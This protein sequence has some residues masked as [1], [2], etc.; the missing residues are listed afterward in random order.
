M[1]I[2]TIRGWASRLRDQ[3]HANRRT[4][5]QSL[6]AGSATRRLSSFAAMGHSATSGLQPRPGRSWAILSPTALCRVTRLRKIGATAPFAGL[7]LRLE[8]PPGRFW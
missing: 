2:L 1:S 8:H 7:V 3:H 5:A 4:P 6:E